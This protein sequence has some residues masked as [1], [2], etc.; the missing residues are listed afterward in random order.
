MVVSMRTEEWAERTILIGAVGKF[1]KCMPTK[2]LLKSYFGRQSH[3]LPKS[4]M[5]DVMSPQECSVASKNQRSDCKYV[6]P[7][8]K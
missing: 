3:S 2:T 6:S 5:S 7:G 8:H 1:V 4:E